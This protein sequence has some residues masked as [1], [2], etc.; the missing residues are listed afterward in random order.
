MLQHSLG[1]DKGY[2]RHFCICQNYQCVLACHSI[3]NEHFFTVC[4][5]RHKVSRIGTYGPLF[6][7]PLLVLPSPPISFFY[8]DNL[9]QTLFLY[10][11]LV[12]LTSLHNQRLTRRDIFVSQVSESRSELRFGAGTLGRGV[13]VDAFLF[14]LLF[15]GFIVSQHQK[16]L[17]YVFLW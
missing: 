12:N 17:C 5:V 8:R 2:A 13:L 15:V 6:V 3:K 10:C 7:F 4:R 9:I 11:L 16:A 14:K 1:S